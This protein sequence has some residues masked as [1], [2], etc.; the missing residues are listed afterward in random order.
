MSTND[1]QLISDYADMLQVGARNMQNY[2]LC[3]NWQNQAS[4]SCSSAALPPA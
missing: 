4:R 2:D 1:I 3:V